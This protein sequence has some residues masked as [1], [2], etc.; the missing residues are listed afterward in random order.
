MRKQLLCLFFILTISAP[1][2]GSVSEA[3]KDIIQEIYYNKSERQIT[4]MEA[5]DRVKE[6]YAANFKKVYEGSED[7]YYYKL[8]IARFYLAYEGETEAKRNYLLHL[9]EFVMDDPGTGLGHTVT[10]GWYTVDKKNGRITDKTEDMI[11]TEL[12]KSN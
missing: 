9:Y 6:R 2:I 11:N 3:S 1:V 8:D 10:Y 4:P 12:D 7:E 5:L